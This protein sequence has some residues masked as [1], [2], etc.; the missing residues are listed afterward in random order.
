MQDKPL[1]PPRNG[2]HAEFLDRC[3]SA[4]EDRPRGQVAV[5][6]RLS[7]LRW[8]ENYCPYLLVPLSLVFDPTPNPP[9]QEGEGETERTASIFSPSSELDPTTVTEGRSASVGPLSLVLHPTPQ[10]PGEG[11]GGGV[12]DQRKET[13]GGGSF[14]SYHSLGEL[15]GTPGTDSPT[16]ALP[17]EVKAILFSGPFEDIPGL[18]LLPGGPSCRSRCPRWTH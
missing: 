3:E 15:R 1:R 16:G 6:W 11:L 17:I 2:S 9:P 4:E 10:P 14:F 12:R 13:N 8:V 7:L 18:S 5:C